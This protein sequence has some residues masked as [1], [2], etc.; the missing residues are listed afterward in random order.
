MIYHSLEARPPLGRHRH[1][2]GDTCKSTGI[3]TRQGG[4]KEKVLN[5]WTRKELKTK[6]KVDLFLLSFHLNNSFELTAILVGSDP[7]SPFCWL[8]KPILY[9]VI[10]AFHCIGGEESMCQLDWL[11]RE[12]TIFAFCYGFHLHPSC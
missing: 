7:C 8:L 10:I 2:W 12:N 5:M 11:E 1:R 4:E 9:A 6:R 3:K